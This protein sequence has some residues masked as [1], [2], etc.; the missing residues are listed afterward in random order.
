MSSDAAA[1]VVFPNIASLSVSG[2]AGVAGAGAGAGAD[3]TGGG[4]APAAVG[5]VDVASIDDSSRLVRV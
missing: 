5:R 4:G 2:A 3:G 1:S